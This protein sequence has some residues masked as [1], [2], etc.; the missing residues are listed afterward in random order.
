MGLKPADTESYLS[1]RE[2]LLSLRGRGLSGVRLMV[3]DAH[4]RLAR[5]AWEVFSG[6]AWQR[7]IANLECDVAE[8]C[9]RR[10]N[11]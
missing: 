3:S 4:D 11:V 5:E 10:G 8:R 2:F 1:W 7:C 6:A 9:R